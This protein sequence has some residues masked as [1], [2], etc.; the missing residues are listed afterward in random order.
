MGK[1]ERYVDFKIQKSDFTG[2]P[3]IKAEVPAGSQFKDL[4]RVQEIL[5]TD[6]LERIGLDSHPACLSGLDAVIM[7]ERFEDV[8][9]FN[10]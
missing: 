7:E 6:V 9:R 8:L 1:E 2:R 5:F 4:A 10:F 3:R